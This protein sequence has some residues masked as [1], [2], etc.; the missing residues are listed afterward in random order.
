MR[1]AQRKRLD[2]LHFY[3]IE[4]FNF[5]RTL[6]LSKMMCTKLSTYHMQENEQM[7]TFKKR[8]TTEFIHL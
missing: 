5:I 7:Y 6:I 8:T 3:K 4:C 1:F 2:L